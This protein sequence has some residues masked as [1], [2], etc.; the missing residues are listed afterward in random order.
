M[1]AIL[2]GLAALALTTT[3]EAATPPQ[4]SFE[5]HLIAAC[6]PG[7]AAL[8]LVGSQEELCL[9]KDK[10]IDGTDVVK[11]ERYPTLPKAVIEIS[12]AAADRLFE[13]TSTGDGEQRLGFVF[14]GK[15]IFAPYV[16]SPIKLKELPLTLKNDPDDIDALV[17]AFPGDMAAK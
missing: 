5:V 10:V 3:A 2:L 1:R 6:K 16:G 9:A 15:L 11:V 17:A 7:E 14:N 12:Q 13:V 8:A 4:A